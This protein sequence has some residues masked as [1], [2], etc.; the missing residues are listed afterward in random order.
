VISVQEARAVLAEVERQRQ[1]P[2]PSD[3]SAAG[4]V[5]ASVAI[6]ATV[7]MP[8]IGRVLAL[9]GTAML[10]VGATLGATALVSGLLGIFGGGRVHGAVATEV[11]ESVQVLA[12]EFPEGDEDRLRRAAVRL[13]TGAYAPA[14][15]ATVSTFDAEQVARRIGRALP[16]VEEL[17][18]FLVERR[19]IAPVFTSSGEQVAERPDPPV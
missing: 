7:L 5:V 17:E 8:F 12:A 10:A 14:G 3:P 16:Y 1:R 2:P 6:I 4:C 9:S 19:E 15:K 18:R 11:E 13:L